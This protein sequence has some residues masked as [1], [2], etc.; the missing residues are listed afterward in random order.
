[1]RGRRVVA[2]PVLVALLAAAAT[3]PA[4]HRQ[5]SV[6][7]HRVRAAVE[8]YNQLLPRV[9]A[10][11]RSELLSPVTGEDE[12]Q[13]IDGLLEDLKA[14]RWTL[15]CRQEASEVTRLAI[16]DPPTMAEVETSE[17]WWYRQVPETGA[18]EV[19]GP[20]RVRYG[21]RYKLLQREGR[22]FVD[23]IEMLNSEELPAAP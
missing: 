6:E 8:S 20:K 21:L 10:T 16:E 11:S 13:R 15:D 12:R 4:C 5:E 1:M 18:A 17:L 22:W 23:R 14:R 3:L 19:P 9:Y 7:E 2:G